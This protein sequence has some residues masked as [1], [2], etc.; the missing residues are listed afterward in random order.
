ML[1]VGKVG[2]ERNCESN[3]PA[4]F[5]SP[6]IAEMPLARN[7]YT[8][9]IML[10]IDGIVWVSGFWAGAIHLWVAPL[11]NRKKEMEKMGENSNMVRINTRIPRYLNDWMDEQ[12]AKTGVPKSTQMLLAMELYYNQKNAPTQMLEFA[13]LLEEAQKLNDKLEEQE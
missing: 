6:A 8:L 11:S 2:A 10:H 3:A 12:S 9:L 5:F 13:R 7:I 1:G 4:P